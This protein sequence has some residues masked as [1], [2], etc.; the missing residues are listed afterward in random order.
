MLHL[1]F[2]PLKTSYETIK[3]ASN[4]ILAVFTSK[5]VMATFIVF[6]AAT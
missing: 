1:I 5:I 6:A 2:E 4:G 3:A